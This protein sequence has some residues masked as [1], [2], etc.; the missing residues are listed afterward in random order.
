MRPLCTKTSTK[1]MHIDY[2][3]YSYNNILK[4]YN[5]LQTGNIICKNIKTVLNKFEGMVKE[6]KIPRYI[7]VTFSFHHIAKLSGKLWEVRKISR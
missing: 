3:A 4:M 1:I 7:L 2:A 5:G 6:I